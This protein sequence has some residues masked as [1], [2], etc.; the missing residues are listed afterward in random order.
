[1]PGILG[2]ALKK[3]PNRKLYFYKKNGAWKNYSNVDLWNILPTLG[4]GLMA[5]GLKEHDKLAI[6]SENSP[7]WCFFDWT[8]SH[9]NFVSIPIYQTSISKQVHYILDHS[10]AKIAVVSTHEQLK[11]ILIIKDKLKYLK[12]VIMLDNKEYDM[13]WVITYDKLK[14]LGAAEELRSDIKME[15]IAAKIKPDDLWSIIYTSG[16]SGDPKGVMISHFNMAAN[17]QQTENFTKFKHHKRWLS[18]LPLSHSFERHS[19]L[20]CTWVGAEFYFSE[21]IAK[22]PENL[23]EVRPQY[24][25]TVPR[26]LEKVYAGVIENI[27]ASSNTKQEIF[28][29]AQRIGHRAVNK[30]LK[31]N[32]RPIGPLAIQYALA[33]KLV[34]DKVADIFGGE[35]TRCIS[36][37]APLAAEIGEFFLMAGI[38]V[39]EGFGLTEMSPISHGNPLEHLKFGYVGKPYPDV[40]T[41]IAIDGEILINGP[42]L[43]KGYYKSPQETAEAIDKDGWFHTG[44]IGFVDEDGYLKITDR[45]KNLIVTAGGKNIAPAGVER[46]ICASKYIDQAVVIGDRQKYLIAIIVPSL[47]LIQEWGKQQNPVRVFKSYEDLT[48][49]N[50]VREL[51]QNELDIHQKELARYEQ[52]KYFFIA[53]QPFAIETGELTA[54][55][56]IKR[57][58][59]IEKYSK[60]IN[61]LYNK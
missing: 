9:F 52:I 6:L 11:K 57:N 12:Y 56:K 1:M 42:N 8:C 19:S 30:Y 26:L 48:S 13:S 58:A 61:E 5:L 43:M 39:Q 25:T 24:M 37:G 27:L 34:F 55:M 16:T 35:F 21:S 47:E 22:V 7:E 23:K 45:K 20:Y 59:I 54:S 14:Q 38:K 60:E 15:S 44:D 18:F 31:Y 49:S 41:K 50:D 4:F 2:D 29:W 28:N 51:L 46:E 36:G 10:E 53:P 33:K 32:K 3:S 17:I 40:K